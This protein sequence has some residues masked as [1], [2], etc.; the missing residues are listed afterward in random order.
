MTPEEVCGRWVHV[1]EEDTEHEMVFR[2]VG[3]PLPPARGR[4]AFELRPDGSFA[5]TGL[6]A[7]DI[8]EE[9]AGDWSVEGDTV[10]LSEG[11]AQGVPR[12]M[13]VVSVAPD[14]LVVRRSG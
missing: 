5:E 13:Q 4:V 11:A 7:A 14:R 8:P 3:T 10:T 2:P 1:R 12:V 6:G 9:A